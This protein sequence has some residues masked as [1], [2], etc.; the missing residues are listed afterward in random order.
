VPRAVSE[1]EQNRRTAAALREWRNA[2]CESE[3]AR[4]EENEKAL[5]DEARESEENGTE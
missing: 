5:G 1:E 4:A 3:E 2:R